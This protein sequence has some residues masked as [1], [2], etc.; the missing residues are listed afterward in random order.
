MCRFGKPRVARCDTIALVGRSS[1]YK[2]ERSQQAEKDGYHLAACGR[3]I[4]WL[5]GSLP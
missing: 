4:I 5:Y 2:S 3:K 1:R